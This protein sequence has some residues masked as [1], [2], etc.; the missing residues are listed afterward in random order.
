MLSRLYQKPSM[1]LLG[2]AK[3]PIFSNLHVRTLANVQANTPRQLDN[4]ESLR[5]TPVSRDSAN[6][7]I[8]DGPIFNGRS[9]GAKSNVSGEAVFTTSL[10]GYNESLTVRNLQSYPV[11]CK[12]SQARL[13]IHGSASSA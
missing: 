3:K 2:A 13:N 5:R 7:T 1:G 11:S 6:L 10:V 8:R 9:F 12:G 4:Q